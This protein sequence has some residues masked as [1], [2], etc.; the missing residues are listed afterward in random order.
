VP[1]TVS[2]RPPA[3][4]SSLLAPRGPWLP[5]LSFILSLALYAYVFG[6]QLGLGLTL[7]LLVHELGHFV[8]IRA[9]G[10]PAALPVFI[11][12]IGAYVAMRRLPPSVRDEA[13][14]ALAGPLA[15]CLSAIA[16]L[17]LYEAT[18]MRLFLSLAYLGYILN[19][20]NLLPLPPLDGG[21]I[22]GALSRWFWL[23]AFVAAI[24]Y[25]VAIQNGL[26]LLITAFAAF[27]AAQYAGRRPWRSPYYRI[28]WLARAYVTLV[29]LGLAAALAV[30]MV[31]THA[32]LTRSL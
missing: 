25:S 7:L 28:S 26:L 3:R 20:L 2:F 9:K 19:L 11:P 14:I 6:W 13:E 12:L 30:G 27:Q 32:L 8:L 17:A 21:R 4:R 23:F 29:Y 15:G 5:T 24:G 22:T 18:A 10:L 1:Q 16:C 31:V